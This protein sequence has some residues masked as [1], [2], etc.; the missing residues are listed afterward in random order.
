MI[1]MAHALFCDSTLIS[2]LAVTLTVFPESAVPTHRECV[3][4]TL[5]H[6]TI[7]YLSHSSALS[8]IDMTLTTW[9][10]VVFQYDTMQNRVHAVKAAQLFLFYY[11]YKS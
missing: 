1:D 3:R 4:V 9:L 11:S 10:N 2:T 5:L 6:V 8:L 7:T